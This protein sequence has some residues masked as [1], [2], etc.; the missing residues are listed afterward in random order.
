ML[1]QAGCHQSQLVD[2]L[3]SLNDNIFRPLSP[4][5]GDHRLDGEIADILE[6]IEYVP[7]GSQLENAGQETPSPALPHESPSA[8]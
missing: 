5:A 1:T 2:A 7:R 6:H 3:S 4:N 8:I